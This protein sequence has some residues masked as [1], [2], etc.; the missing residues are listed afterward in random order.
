MSSPLCGLIGGVVDLLSAKN[1]F[2]V[3]IDDPTRHRV[4]QSVFH[5]YYA[6]DAAPIIF[7]TSRAWCARMPLLNAFFPEGKVIACVRQLPWILDS[8]ERLV[9]KNFLQPSSIFQYASSGTV[10]SRC[11][12]LSKSD[13][14]V[15]GAFN[16]LKD[17]YYGPFAIGRLLLLQYE[18][19]VADPQ[20]AIDAIY[21]FI[22]EPHF[23]HDFDNVVFDADAFDQR[24]GTPGLHAI[25]RRV[26]Y[27]ERQSVLP[28]DIFARHM[29]D[30]FWLNP[31]QSRNDVPIV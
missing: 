2:A 13:G 24:A 28:P 12:H 20:K 14:M 25:Y 16:A 18:S 19:L 30:A 7:D 8:V 23:S 26:Q 1:P 21:A 9:Q 3:F 31:D 4:I 27:I 15:G 17:A 10:Y 11:E 5:S 29:A 22:G 6:N